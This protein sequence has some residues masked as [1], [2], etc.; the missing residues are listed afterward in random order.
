MLIL[1]VFQWLTQRAPVYES[2][3]SINKPWQSKYLLVL[4][5]LWQ[6]ILIYII[7]YCT[8]L[9]Y[10]ALCS[11][12]CPFNQTQDMWL[13]MHTSRWPF[14]YRAVAL[15]AQLSCL[16]QIWAN[17]WPEWVFHW[18]ICNQCTAFV[19]C[20]VIAVRMKTFYMCICVPDIV[21]GYI[22]TEESEL[23]YRWNTDWK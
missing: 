18:L 12:S 21:W 3:T 17:C 6:V 4:L 10:V 7:Q 19:F 15:T 9:A 20:Y 14:V 5:I 8:H 22:Q 23:L 2:F 1:F 16:L 11:S 13:L